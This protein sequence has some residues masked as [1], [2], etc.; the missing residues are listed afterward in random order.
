MDE[1]L[2]QGW[3]KVQKIVFKK[4]GEKLDAQTILFLIGLQELGMTQKN[5]KKEQKLDVI[6]I[7]ICTVLSPFGYYKFI[8][9][10]EEGWPHFKNIKKL[11][12]NIIGEEQDNFLKK[13]I[14]NYL[15]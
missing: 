9:K 5:F 10:D 6:H 11:P 7:G 14:I 1:V 12:N 4:F 3:Q 15:V 8:G 13:A 2:E